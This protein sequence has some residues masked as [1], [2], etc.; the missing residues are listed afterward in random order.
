MRHSFSDAVPMV[1]VS[2]RERR[3]MNYE[4]FRSAVLDLVGED[5]EWNVVT[6]W[7]EPDEYRLVG[8]TPAEEVPSEDYIELEQEKGPYY[9]FM[10]ISVNRLFVRYQTEGWD[11][12]RMELD[13]YAYRENSRAH[14]NRGIDYEARLSEEDAALYAQLRELRSE[15]A[16]R[17]NV[18]PY[19]IF[20]NRTLYEMCVNRPAEIGELREIY[21]YGGTL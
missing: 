20:M 19:T 11:A 14:R 6:G 1:R 12:V 9:F 2:D 16:R 13:K 3:K 8:T 4:V 15:T 10:M 17:R 18:P 5:K 7:E 21:G